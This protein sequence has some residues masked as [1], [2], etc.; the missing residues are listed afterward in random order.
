MGQ[1]EAPAD[2][3]AIAEELLDLIG[4][5]GRADV[6]VLGAPSEQQIADAAA[7]KVSDVVVL[8]E[9]IEDFE[10]VWINVA[11]RDRVLGARNDPGNGHRA[12]CTKRPNGSY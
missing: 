4:M 1:T 7:D 10:C 3:P 5:G 6:E 2:D 9:A 12:H 11:A 8:T